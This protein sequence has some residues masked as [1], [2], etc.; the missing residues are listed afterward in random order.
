M[1]SESNLFLAGG[2]IG[3]WRKF[4]RLPPGRQITPMSPVPN[5]SNVKIFANSAHPRKWMK[6]IVEP[7]R[8]GG[9]VAL[10]SLSP[11]NWFG[12]LVRYVG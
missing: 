10:V 2:S 11:R 6:I 7:K 1:F 4:R 5:S 8:R 3:R 9:T 12:T